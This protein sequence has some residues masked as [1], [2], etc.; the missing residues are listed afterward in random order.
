M[1]QVLNPATRAHRVV[2]EQALCHASLLIERLL[3]YHRNLGLVPRTSTVNDPL[4]PIVVS[5]DDV[6]TIFAG[7]RRA[8]KAPQ[9]GGLAADPL[10][11]DL[12]ASRQ[13]LATAL[14][15]PESRGLGF[16]EIVRTLKLVD[17]A[18]DP[19]L[20]ALTPDW[21]ARIGRLFGFL[22][23]DTTRQR[24]TVGHLQLSLDQGTP[25]LSPD[26][27]EKLDRYLI[28]PG[29][30]E[31][32]AV[33]E[34]PQPSQGVH[35][36]PYIVEL[37]RTNLL[38]QGDRAEPRRWNQL[39]W[40]EEEKS[41][42]AGGLAREISLRPDYRR[43]IIL[44]GT[45]GSG[46][47][48]AAT[49]AALDLNMGTVE[50]VL[51]PD[52]IGQLEREL[53]SSIFRAKIC[54]SLLIVRSDGVLGGHPD[55]WRKLKVLASGLEVRCIVLVRPDEAIPTS[56]T[57]SFVRFSPPLTRPGDRRHLWKETLDKVGLK[58]DPQELNYLST[59][60]DVTPGRVQE[61][62][63]ELT[64]RS[65]SSGIQTVTVHDASEALRDITTRKLKDQ[66]N[67]YV[68]NQTLKDLVLDGPSLD[69]LNELIH[70]MKNRYQILDDW[71][72]GGRS[73]HGYGLAALFAGPPG[74]GK[75]AAAAAVARALEIDIYIVDLSRIMSKWIGETE[76]NLARIFDE[77]EASSVALLFDE[78][79]SLFGKRSTEM[80]S[81]TDRFANITVNYLLQRM[82]RYS[83][84]AILTTNLESAIDTAFSRRIT[85]RVYFPMPDEKHRLMLWHQLLPEGVSYAPDV[86]LGPLVRQ[87]EMPGARIRSSILRAAFRAAALGRQDR[88]ITHEDLVWAALLEY[89]DMGHLPPFK[90]PSAISGS[91][92][93]D[94][95]GPRDESD[96]RDEPM[97]SSSII[98]RV[99]PPYRSLRDV[100][101][102]KRF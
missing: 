28:R 78:A 8:G 73:S 80:K 22:N 57:L 75:T 35:V 77:A 85:T 17:T 63:A 2:F 24:P 1:T 32:E 19:F 18:L 55:L 38:P 10:S 59:R 102:P 60:F 98:E 40:N 16:V 89:E 93:D 95:A 67:L 71:R 34:T 14:S 50:C 26:A 25:S 101:F 48:A 86:D 70:R 52:P 83:G 7:F 65:K 92:E 54:E 42:L 27:Q 12:A 82:E 56:N 49:A 29:L 90:A 68:G 9:T 53:S 23:N 51:G 31:V 37:S 81:S 72:F 44:E 100:P 99:L 47:C 39:Y 13:A 41:A 15:A 6:A 20:L 30:I 84:L 91:A 76:Q 11:A 58:S 36:P 79:D 97:D 45:P 4:G 3:F 21:D 61:L 5:D 33:S 62:A 66:A 94:E 69:R 64:F 46:R 96:P 88:A 87:L 74:T 43:L